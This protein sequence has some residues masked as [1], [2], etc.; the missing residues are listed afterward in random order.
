MDNMTHEDNR[1]PNKTYVWGV[2]IGD[3]AVCYTQ[4]FLVGHGNLINT[5]IGG[6][7][8]VLAW[9]PLYESVGAYYNKGDAPVTKID[10]FGNS[11]QGKLTRVETLKSGMFWHVWAEFFSHTDINRIDPSVSHVA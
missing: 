9:G 2:N 5:E 1:L 3:D 4:D 10:F 8:I 11:D 7:K 6:R